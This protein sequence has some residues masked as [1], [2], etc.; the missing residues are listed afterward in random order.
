MT[1]AIQFGPIVLRGVRDPVISRLYRDPTFQEICL[2]CLASY[3]SRVLKYDHADVLASFSPPLTI[4]GPQIDKDGWWPKIQDIIWAQ[5]RHNPIAYNERMN[6]AWPV[7]SN[8][9]RVFDV[10]NGRAQ[11][12]S[13]WTDFADE[14]RCPLYLAGNGRLPGGGG[15]VTVGAVH[16]AYA[17]GAFAQAKD[18]LRFEQGVGSIQTGSHDRQLSLESL[19]FVPIAG[20][21][22]MQRIP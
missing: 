9:R 7:D 18:R 10:I 4:F 5:T 14:T 21:N 1:V 12:R 13:F 22:E 20:H 2:A 15:T 11:P 19:G 16:P 3:T 8:R 6:W 17:S